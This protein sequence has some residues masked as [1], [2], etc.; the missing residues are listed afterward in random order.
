MRK[1]KSFKFYI[2]LITS[3]LC[4]IIAVNII[5]TPVHQASKG[6]EKLKNFINNTDNL[7]DGFGFGEY[8]ADDQPHTMVQSILTGPE[9][10]MLT[11]INKFDLVENIR[12]DHK[13]IWNTFISIAALWVIGVAMLHFFQNVERGRD[14]WESVCQ[15]L[16]EIAITG[17]FII[18]LGLLL[19]I[20]IQL[21]T[22]FITMVTA[23]DITFGVDEDKVNKVLIALTGDKQGTAL[24][25][26]EAIA[27]LNFPYTMN[28]IVCIIGIMMMLQIQIDLSIRILCAP[29]AVA[30]IYQEGLRSPGARYL[31]KL[32][33]ISIKAALACIIAAIGGEFALQALILLG[34]SSIAL[35]TNFL[36]IIGIHMA[37]IA[38]IKGLDG[39]ANDIVG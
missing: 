36:Y 9:S 3:I 18:N 28:G 39:L 25:H 30:D 33:V 6:F 7:L 21:G 4:A 24:W 29:L 35:Q 2:N 27:I 20:I 16:V 12:E 32:F 15:V 10:I 37:T 17:I 34:D 31:K 8:R 13:I 38:S 19:D 14:E 26:Q 23:A 1:E 22:Q 11:I 5:F